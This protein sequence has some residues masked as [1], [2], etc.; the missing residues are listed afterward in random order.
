VPRR[1]TDSLMKKLFQILVA[2]GLR[3]VLQRCKQ[4]PQFRL[5]DASFEG[6]GLQSGFRD[7]SWERLRA[8]IYEGRGG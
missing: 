4:H 6:K 1:F 2:T 7:A 3:N 5:R 8:A